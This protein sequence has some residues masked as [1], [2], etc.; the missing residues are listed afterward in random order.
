MQIN[1]VQSYSQSNKNA[2]FTALRGVKY[3]NDFNPQESPEDVVIIKN[4]LANKNIKNLLKKYDVWATFDKHQ[5]SYYMDTQY[6]ILS[7]KCK[8]VPVDSG[9]KSIFKS[10]KF[11]FQKDKRDSLEIKLG[12]GY[13]CMQDSDMVRLSNKI[14][15]VTDTELEL[16]LVR[17]ERNLLANKL[18]SIGVNNVER[19]LERQL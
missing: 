18:H 12:G 13:D 6:E 10:I 16:Q 3:I 9:K 11:L 2:S 1:Q 4:F 8:K 7:M 15:N 19:N 17:S 14:K 5:D